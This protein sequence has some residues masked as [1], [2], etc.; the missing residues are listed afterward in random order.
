[1]HKFEIKALGNRTTRLRNVL[2]FATLVVA[3]FG[4]PALAVKPG[5]KSARSTA[6]VTIS[7][8]VHPSV[9]ARHMNRSTL[10]P[11]LESTNSLDEPDDYLCLDVRDT[12]TLTFFVVTQDT[13]GSVIAPVA[14]WSF[15]DAPISNDVDTERCPISV[16][17][18]LSRVTPT[19]NGHMTLLVSPE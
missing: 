19:T 1:M 7:L 8:E 5:N 9:K 15:A 11:N 2:W 18:N 12:R 17:L 10:E 4:L 3:G 13:N 14:N 6:T 16:P